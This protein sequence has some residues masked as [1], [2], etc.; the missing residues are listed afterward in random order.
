MNKEYGRA[1]QK[2]IAIAKAENGEEFMKAYK[3]MTADMFHRQKQ[4]V[5]VKGL[6]RE[7]SI[8]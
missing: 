4:K 2:G 5:T 3:A 7:A 6:F 1:L 8:C